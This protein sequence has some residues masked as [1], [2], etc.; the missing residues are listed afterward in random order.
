[1][2]EMAIGHS[3]L[4]TINSAVGGSSY[5]LYMLVIHRLT[6]GRN[7]LLVKS[8]TSGCAKAVARAIASYNGIFF[9]S[10]FDVIGKIQDDCY[11]QEMLLSIEILSVRSIRDRA[12]KMLVVCTQRIWD[13]HVFDRNLP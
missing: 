8:A 10:I 9:K 5:R 1:M 3:M 13:R 7:F 11:V 4:L 2:A 6:Q 12:Y